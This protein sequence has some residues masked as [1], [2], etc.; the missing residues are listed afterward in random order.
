[1]KIGEALSKEG[2]ITKEQLQTALA[3]QEKTH[4]RLGDIV[5]KMGFVTAEQMAPFLAQ[6]FEISFVDIKAIYKDIKPEI[7]DCIPAEL[8]HRFTVIPI[9]LRNNVL[10]VAMF[11]PLAFF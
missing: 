1:M 5:L 2:L 3:Q 9:E 4:D 8:A 10:T 6:Y 11:D 7:I